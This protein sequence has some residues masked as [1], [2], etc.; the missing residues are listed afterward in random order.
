MI[1]SIIGID[2]G[3]GFTKTTDGN[4]F[5]VFKSIYGE[6]VDFQ[7]RENLLSASSEEEH[8]HIDIDGESYF[9]G[10]LAERQSSNRAF[11]LDQTQFVA[12]S[13]KVLALAALSKI[14]PQPQQ[15]VRLVVGLPIGH[16]RQYKSELATMLRATHQITTT[17]A[18]GNRQEKNL[19][20]SEVRV[21]PQPIGTVMDRLLSHQ[22][23][24]EHK[25]F[26]SDKIGIIDVGF[27]TTDY[28]ISDKGRYSERGSL[29]TQNG[30]SKAFTTIATKLKETCNVEIEIYRLFDAVEQGNIKVRGK[31]YDLQKITD[32]A[33]QQLA[34]SIASDANQ[35]WADDWDIDAIM[36]TGGGGAVLAPYIQPLI[37]GVI[38]PIEEDLD[39][40]LH[41]VRGYY[42]FGVNT[43]GDKAS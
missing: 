12:T 11:T 25:R 30:I 8:L 43:W 32:H 2:I 20:I 21:L 22:G 14:L 35:V 15:S 38:I 3:F 17:D 1:D 6:A 37:E 36:I 39:Y 29:T 41:N 28:T 9:V 26:A 42:K 10:E 23:L 13:S 19:N 31:A 4:D 40:R 34:A 16:Y 7:F 33:F 18:Q 27:R 5:L 24:P